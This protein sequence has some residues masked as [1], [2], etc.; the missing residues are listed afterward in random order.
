MLLNKYE[1]AGYLCNANLNEPCTDSKLQ[2]FRGE[3]IVMEGEMLDASGR[4]KPP[5]TVLP[6]VALLADENR[7]QFIAGMLENV[8]DIPALLARYGEDIG[9]DTLGV[10]FVYNID[11]AVTLNHHGSNLHLIPMDDGLP[12]SELMQ[13]AGLEKAD[14]KNLAPADKVRAVFRELTGFRPRGAATVELAA[15]PALSN[16]KQRE[17]RGAV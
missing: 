17:I 14:I 7:L 13:L 2:A 3:L 1:Q 11:K 16:G 4:R 12:W 8:A 6:Q 5:L 15:L 10:I 9:G